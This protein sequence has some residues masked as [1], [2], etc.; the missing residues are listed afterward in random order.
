M[1]TL[2]PIALRYGS[3]VSQI[4]DEPVSADIDEC[5]CSDCDKSEGLKER[6][7]PHWDGM[8]GSK[9]EEW[10]PLQT[11]LC[12]PRVL[13]YVLKDKRWAQFNV[14]NLNDIP[15]ESYESVM[16]R[17]HLVGENAGA[18]IKELLYGLVKHHGGGTAKRDNKSYVIDD[19]VAEK[20]KGLVF[21]LYGYI[22]SSLFLR[23]CS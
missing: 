14:D 16:S 6:F 10:E 3:D 18:E 13:G 23:S 1:L 2:S 12:P 11:M 20:G 22:I 4:G 9:D 7:K 17:L 21:L 5:R 15:D 8:T 19:I